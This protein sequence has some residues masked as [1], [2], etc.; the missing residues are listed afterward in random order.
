MKI[1]LILFLIYFIIRCIVLA[2]QNVELKALLVEKHLPIT[3]E[4]NNIIKEDFLKFVSDSREW[5]FDYIEEVQNALLTFDN[6]IKDDLKYFEQY[7]IIMGEER[8][9]YKMLKNISNAYK[10]LVK[11]LPDNR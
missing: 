5:A 8:P 1:V 9:D 2:K 3:P 7:G 11:V 10:D 4:E 6:A